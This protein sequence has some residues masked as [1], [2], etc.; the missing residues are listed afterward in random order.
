MFSC[1]LKECPVNLTLHMRGSIKDTH[2]IDRDPARFEETDFRMISGPNPN[3]GA[4]MD[5]HDEENAIIEAMDAARSDVAAD[6]PDTDDF[7][8]DVDRAYAEIYQRFLA[9]VA[10]TG[11][12]AEAADVH[13]K[14]FDKSRTSGDSRSDAEEPAKPVSDKLLSENDIR[15]ARFEKKFVL[16]PN[17]IGIRRLAYSVVGLN[18]FVSRMSRHCENDT[19]SWKNARVVHQYL[20]HARRGE[21][22]A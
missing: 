8:A 17:F 6:S 20:R 10:Q 21:T 5:L 12:E 3:A 19:Y 15:V 22:N 4:D 18:M 7:D 9:E 16:V 2:L 13:R 14:H 11:S 1:V